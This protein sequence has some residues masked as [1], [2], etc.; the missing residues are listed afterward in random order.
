M[1]TLYLFLS[2]SSVLSAP[3]KEEPVSNF[4]HETAQCFP[5]LEKIIHTNV[6]ASS[7]GV[8][9]I[10]AEELYDLTPSKLKPYVGK[11][12]RCQG[13]IRGAFGA[14]S[15]KPQRLLTSSLLTPN[16]NDLIERMLKSSE[17]VGSYKS[18]R[19]LILEY[20]EKNGK[21]FK[22]ANSFASFVFFREKT[23]SSL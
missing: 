19:T 9:S 23:N 11:Q 15:S 20:Y 6:Q 7:E 14:T 21:R 5:I 18:I 22:L 3:A 17:P 2:V 1:R 13:G 12:I 10:S 4:L 16:E 8:V